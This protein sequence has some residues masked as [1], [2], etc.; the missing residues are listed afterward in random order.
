[1]SVD[2]FDGVA[3]IAVG[4]TDAASRAAGRRTLVDRV[5]RTASVQLAD[6]RIVGVQRPFGFPPT[7]PPD[8]GSLDG[9]AV[10]VVGL[11]ATPPHRETSR[12]HVPSLEGLTDIAGSVGTGSWRTERVAVVPPVRLT[13]LVGCRPLDG[14][15]SHLGLVG[16]A[17]TLCG[18]LPLRGDPVAPGA[19]DCLRCLRSDEIAARHD[20]QVAHHGAL[21]AL[22]GP[23][24]AGVADRLW[25]RFAHRHIAEL[26]ALLD[27]MVGAII[28]RVPGAPSVETTLPHVQRHRAVASDAVQRWAAAEALDR[29][30][31]GLVRA[32]AA[33]PV[34]LDRDTRERL[35]VVSDLVDPVETA[36]L[37]VRVLEE[38]GPAPALEPVALHLAERAGD[39]AS[40]RVDRWRR[41]HTVARALSGVPS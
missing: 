36:E 23:L 41:I 15:G 7:L 33:H 12:E 25:Q 13:D 20:R 30:T 8:P 21:V 27:A 3:L 16:Q 18:R 40:P 28:L 32:A 39:A 17:A 14:G 22:T 2:G 26:P 1:V 31:R 19:V 29:L 37:V 10:V 4:G 6:R 34:S 38:H 35:A 11:R 5:A 24:T 9:E